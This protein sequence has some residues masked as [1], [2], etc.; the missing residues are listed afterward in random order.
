MSEST[1][2]IEQSFHGCLHVSS[3]LLKHLDVSRLVGK[4][5]SLQLRQ[6][7]CEQGLIVHVCVG[8]R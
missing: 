2:H 4:T 3:C 7:L 8:L 1:Q 6:L 5:H